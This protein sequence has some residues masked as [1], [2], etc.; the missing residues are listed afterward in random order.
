[1]SDDRETRAALAV[2]AAEAG[3]AVAAQRF[4]TG[5]DVEVKGGKTDV[6]TEADRL[7]QRRVIEAIRGEFPD[8]AVVGEEE[9]ERKTVPEDGA[10]WVIDPIDGTNN[11]VRDGRVWA[12]S[13]AAVVDGEAVA[14]ANV[15][16]AMGDTYA[17]G[18]DGVTR[19]GDP[20]AVSDAA[21]PEVFAVSP[22][23]WWPRDRRDE[24]AAV[25]REVV[26]RFGDVRRYGC[27]QAT[28][29][30]VADGG[31]EAAVTNLRANPWDTVAGVEMVRAA[32]GVVTDVYGDRWRHDSTGL[33]ASNGEAHGE[34]LEAVR[35]AEE[36]PR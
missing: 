29:S 1:M 24:Y 18:P 15:L 7:A 3:A 11:F 33:V 13:V 8:D 12:T 14:A 28:L 21:D 6:V 16:P 17:V 10:A 19:N 2:E 27:A 23:V 22:T 34:L 25:V 31:L 5:I 20:V 26:E 30:M 32:G 36:P 35:V 4:R 9:D